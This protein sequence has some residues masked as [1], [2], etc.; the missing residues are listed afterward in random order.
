MKF[1]PLVLIFCCFSMGC[2]TLNLKK[3]YE[4]NECVRF[5]NMMTNLLEPE[6]LYPLQEACISSKAKK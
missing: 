1:F 6:A 5:K 4:T 2:T 3:N